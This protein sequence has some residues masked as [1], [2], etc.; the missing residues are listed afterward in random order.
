MNNISE[1]KPKSPAR[2]PIQLIEKPKNLT[3]SSKEIN[4]NKKNNSLNQIS[5]PS[6]K[7]DICNT[8]LPGL[9][10]NNLAPN[11]FNHQCPLK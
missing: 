7:F 5:S 10:N 4:T 2:P 8:T 1:P 11:N 3:T 9:E 6:N